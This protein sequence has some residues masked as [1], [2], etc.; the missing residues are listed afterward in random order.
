MHWMVGWYALGRDSMG[1]RA[2]GMGTTKR[3]GI[4][5]DALWSLMAL[6]RKIDV[7]VV[8]AIHVVDGDEKEQR[9][10]E[11]KIESFL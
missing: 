7:V 9:E 2:K 4:E 5:A 1:F 6:L 3:P 10:I 8:D 11:R